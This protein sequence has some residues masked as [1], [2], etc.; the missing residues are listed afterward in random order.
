MIK[1]EINNDAKQKIT[2][3]DENNKKIE[4]SLEYKPNQ[5]GWF[6]NLIYGDF[7]LSGFRLTNCANL[8]NAWS[9]IIPFGLACYALQNSEPYLKED[10]KDGRASLF[11]LTAN[12]VNIVKDEIYIN[13]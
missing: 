13:V 5:L 3:L 12:E 7:A 1:L 2:V 11:L 6:C 9:D 10:F 8:L 4:L